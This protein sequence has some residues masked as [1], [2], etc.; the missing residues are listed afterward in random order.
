MK[1]NV[2][3]SIS[4]QAPLATVKAMVEDFNQWN[5][6]SPWTVLEPDCTVSV[7]GTANTPGHSMSWDGEVIGAGN[8]TLI[9]TSEHTLD[10]ALEFLKPWKSKADVNFSFE[11]G[12]GATT[13]TW[14]M[15][16]SMPFFLFFMV[17]MMK[18]MIAMDYDRGLKMLKAII[19]EGA[20]KA[21]TINNA[22]VDYQGFSYIGIERTLPYSDMASAM[23][24]DFEKNRERRGYPRP[25]KC[26]ALGVYLP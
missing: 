18:N 7:T 19:E 25:T 5:A 23:Q 21:E 11:E 13:V 26:H 20:V 2:S 4:I 9:K 3:R 10:Y 16:S 6:W 15:H 12:D 14:T 1:L 17:K 22:T 8:N 24:K